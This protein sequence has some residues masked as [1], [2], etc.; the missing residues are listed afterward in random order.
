M[1]ENHGKSLNKMVVITTDVTHLPWA[2][3]GRDG[4][5]FGGIVKRGDG[6]VGLWH[7]VPSRYSILLVW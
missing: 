6:V 1:V 5:C 4:H 2:I 7:R 3:K